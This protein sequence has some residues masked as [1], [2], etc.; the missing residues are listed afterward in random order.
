LKLGRPDRLAPALGQAISNLRVGY[1]LGFT[2]EHA[3]EDERFHRL[4]VKLDTGRSCPG[5]RVQARTGYFS[6]TRKAPQDGAGQPY[7]CKEVVAD[8]SARRAVAVAA[9]TR[10][11]IDLPPFSVRTE[12]I[13]AAGGGFQIRVNLA[14]DNKDIVF[15]SPDGHLSGTLVVCV[16]YTDARGRMLGQE[17]KTAKLQ[18]MPSADFQQGI[19]VAM[20]IPLKEPRQILKVIVY[21]VLSHEAALRCNARCS[22]SWR[23]LS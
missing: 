17:W 22:L 18:G 12:T 5:C 2:P 6:G 1:T 20:T 21:D 19:Q 13:E 16:L 3:G 8:H 23:L 14:I 11:D 7:S 4:T 10:N 15:G 9:H